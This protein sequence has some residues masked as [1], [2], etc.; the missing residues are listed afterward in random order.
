MRDRS[1][2]DNIDVGVDLILRFF[3]L[4]GNF[5]VTKELMFNPF[6]QTIDL[7]SQLSSREECKHIPT[8]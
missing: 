2:F 7:T 1:V 6:H 5:S 4:F 8:T 3:E